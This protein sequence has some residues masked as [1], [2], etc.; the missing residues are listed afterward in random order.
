MSFSSLYVARELSISFCYKVYSKSTNR[1][2]SRQ[3]LLHC[4]MVV[5]QS[6]QPLFGEIEQNPKIKSRKVFLKLQGIIIY[7]KMQLHY[8]FYQQW[9]L[10]KIFK[11]FQKDMKVILINNS[12]SNFLQLFLEVNQLKIRG[13]IL[14]VLYLSLIRNLIFC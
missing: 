7:I 4:C 8:L 1:L 11:V 9:K 10:V 6:G 3:T 14:I 12:I 13:F 5:G 2:H